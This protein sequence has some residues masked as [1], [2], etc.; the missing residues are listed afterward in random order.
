MGKE[1]E[2]EGL[3]WY[4]WVTLNMLIS[5]VGVKIVEIMSVEIIVLPLT[6]VLSLSTQYSV[7]S[8]FSG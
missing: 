2:G 5:L 8:A 6:C 4:M 7:P 1:R 3:S